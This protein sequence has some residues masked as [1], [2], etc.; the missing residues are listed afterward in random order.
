MWLY[1]VSV[2]SATASNPYSSI[3]GFE[4][5]ETRVEAWVCRAESPNN[6]LK[7]LKDLSDAFKYGPRN[8]NKRHIVEYNLLQ[9]SHV[10]DETGVDLLSDLSVHELTDKY[11]KSIFDND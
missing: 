9:M 8:G 1:T 6:G 11:V 3:S 10:P 7:L 5:I 4:N 2:W